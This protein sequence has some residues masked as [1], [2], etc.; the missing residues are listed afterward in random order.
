MA[1][2]RQCESV[3]VGAASQ[4]ERPRTIEP[5]R[6]TQQRGQKLHN[7]PRLLVKVV[8]KPAPQ[9]SGSSTLVDSLSAV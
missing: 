6:N 7:G 3:A 1:I 4:A 8:I 2:V 5:E 9:A